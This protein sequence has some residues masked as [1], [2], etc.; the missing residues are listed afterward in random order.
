[1]FEKISNRQRHGR[2]KDRNERRSFNYL[3]AQPGIWDETYTAPSGFV[4]IAGRS[5]I[6]EYKQD[7]ARI[8]FFDK[9]VSRPAIQPP[10]MMLSNWADDGN[11]GAASIPQNMINIEMAPLNFFR[12]KSNY[13]F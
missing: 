4:R 11:G 13:K 1:M 3:D 2:K 8:L 7:D 10:M 9:S 5:P 12:E 6:Y